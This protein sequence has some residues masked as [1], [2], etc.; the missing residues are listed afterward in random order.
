M[1]LA[2]ARARTLSAALAAFTAASDCLAA[3]TAIRDYLA[4]V[5]RARESQVFLHRS[6]FYTV[7][8]VGFERAS[9]IF[10]QTAMVVVRNC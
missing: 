3:S 1:L 5:L 8:F 6:R 10:V 4:I 2:Q 7:Q 9:L